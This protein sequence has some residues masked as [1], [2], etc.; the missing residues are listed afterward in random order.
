MG[1]C[2]HTVL[3]LQNTWRHEGRQIRSTT[4]A[5]RRSHGLESTRSDL[6]HVR[7]IEVKWP[8]SE[9][10][11][12]ATWYLQKRPIFRREAII[13][14]SD[15][16]R[17]TLPMIV[18]YGIRLIPIVRSPETRSNGADKAWKNPRSRS[19]RAAIAARS[20][21]NH[22]IFVGES[23]LVDRQAIDEGTGPR[24]WPDRGPIVARSWRKLW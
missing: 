10:Y 1:L 3:T 19:D 2:S 6:Q 12:I 5:R 11:A 9:G 23:S 7:E 16:W 22:S 24:S 20:S 17:R 4:I 21:R 8:R 15:G 14:S 18:V 13:K